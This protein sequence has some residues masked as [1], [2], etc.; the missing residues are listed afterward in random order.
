MPTELGFTQELGGLFAWAMR[1]Q[2]RVT[3]FLGGADGDTIC[4]NL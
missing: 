2:I 4:R 1:P 3:S